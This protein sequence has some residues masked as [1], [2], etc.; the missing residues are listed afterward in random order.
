MMNDDEASNA[1]VEA[2]LARVT[3]PTLVVMGTKDPDFKDPVAEAQWIA[4]QVHGTVL[5]V[6]GA[7]YYPH[8]EMPEQVG[9]EITRFLSV[10]TGHA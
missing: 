7:G 9:P 2:S 8:V 10:A 4:D 6:A 3:A 5:L 1:A